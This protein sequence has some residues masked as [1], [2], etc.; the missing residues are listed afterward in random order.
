MR[1][2]EVGGHRRERRIED[3]VDW[4]VGVLQRDAQI[5]IEKIAANRDRDTAE[6]RIGD[7]DAASRRA[8][9]PLGHALPVDGE[10]RGDMFLLL[11]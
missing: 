6:P 11:P 4:R 5:E 7:R 10:N 2:L 1:R 9:N 3:D 8:A